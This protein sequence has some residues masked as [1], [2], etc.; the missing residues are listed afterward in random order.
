MIKL[1]DQ[2]KVWELE[3]AAHGREEYEKGYEEGRME[4]RADALR[5]ILQ[6]LSIQEASE[7]TGIPQDEI[8][9]LTKT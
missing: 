9:R 1:F 5:R 8:E 2:E 7:I 6:K 4:V 3:L